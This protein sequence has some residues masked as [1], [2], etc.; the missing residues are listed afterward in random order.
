MILAPSL[1]AIAFWV[2]IDSEGPVF[3]R[4]TRVGKGLKPFRLFKFRTMF[5][6][7]GK[8]ECQF[9]PGDDRRVTRVGKLLRSTKLDELPELFNVL[10]GDMSIIGPRP[11]VPKYI[12]HYKEEFKKILKLR[13][14]LSDF[15]S[16]RYRDEEL[17]L[18]GRKDS[19]GYYINTIL[20]DK[21][22]MAENYLETISLKTDLSLILKTII[23]IFRR[24]GL[25][26]D[27]RSNLFSVIPVLGNFHLPI[28]V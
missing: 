19:E 21:L 14:G 2:K 13:S 25:F 20:P 23:S 8:L 24:K 18:A 15:A 28:S 12:P 16:I 7:P 3:F 22:N 26:T 27:F 6:N 1:M 10:S 4:Q 5:C 9:E 11:E 17:I